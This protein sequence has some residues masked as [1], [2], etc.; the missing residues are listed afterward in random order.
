VKAGDLISVEIQEDDHSI[1]RTDR[2]GQAAGAVAGG[3]LFGPAGAV[4]GGLSSSNTSRDKC[5]R[6]ALRILTADLSNPNFVVTILRRPALKKTGWLKHGGHYKAAL[7]TA[8]LWHARITALIR[9]A[10][11]EG[12]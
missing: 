9:L 5:E 6:L 8:E 10:E 7:A 2:T 3:L 11:R 12:A 4:V 1:L